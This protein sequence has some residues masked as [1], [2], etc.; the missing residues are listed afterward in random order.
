MIFLLKV[1]G[2]RGTPWRYQEQLPN[3]DPGVKCWRQGGLKSL[4]PHW[5]AH[6]HVVNGEGGS[7]V[8][9]GLFSNFRVRACFPES[10][11]A[12]RMLLELSFMRAADCS[13]FKCPGVQCVCRNCPC[14]SCRGS[15]SRPAAQADS[16]GAGQWDLLKGPEAG[17]RESDFWSEAAGQSRL[18]WLHGWL[19]AHSTNVGPV[20]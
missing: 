3:S 13:D 20:L 4:R 17:W 6:L 18:R 10:L 9:L 7:G 19:C 5:A 8:S 11:R 14:S 16:G 2:P 1:T 15:L 12:E